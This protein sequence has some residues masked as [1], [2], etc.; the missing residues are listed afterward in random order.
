MAESLTAIFTH[1][2][3]ST[4]N[5]NDFINDSI[6]SELYAYIT[7]ILKNLG[8]DVY[9]I[10]GTENH[11]HILCSLSKNRPLT[12]IIKEIKQSSSKWIRRFFS[13]FQPKRYCL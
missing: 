10:G 11:I 4:K 5:R 8:C 13:W 12:E 1:I 6:S 9:R 2:V 7:T 3:F